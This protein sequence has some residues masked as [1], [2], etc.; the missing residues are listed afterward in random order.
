MDGHDADSMRER[1]HD[2]V[3]A[4]CVKNIIGSLRGNG[5]SFWFMDFQTSRK[6][7]NVPLE[8]FGVKLGAIFIKDLLGERPAH[9]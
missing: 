7:K 6:E 8:I 5:R 1:T 2:T 9:C 4:A 3:Y